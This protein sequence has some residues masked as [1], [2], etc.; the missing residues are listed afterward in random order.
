[1]KLLFL[2]DSITDAYHC[3][4]PENLGEGYVRMIYDSLNTPNS[5]PFP[6]HV[7][8]TKNINVS[9]KGIDGFTISRVYDMWRSL[10]DKSCWNTISILAGINDVGA[11]MDRGF[12]AYQLQSEISSFSSTFEDLVTDIL[13]HDVNQIILMEPFIFPFPEKYRIWQPWVNEISLQIQAIAKRYSL[14]YL[15]LQSFLSKF[16]LTEGY[17]AITSDGIH[18]T[19]KGN[20]ILADAWMH[21]FK[22][23]K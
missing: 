3:F 16:A 19:S 15:P 4:D 2:G 9:N 1:M 5:N 23:Q 6:S 18:L 13:D 8:S 17:S 22:Y 10:P 20:R 7:S 12:S 11:W 14:T 21:M